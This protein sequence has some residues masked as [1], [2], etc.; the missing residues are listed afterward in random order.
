MTQCVN[1]PIQ[2][3]LFVVGAHLPEVNLSARSKGQ[4]Q[5]TYKLKLLK[6][7]IR[8]VDI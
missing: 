7:G 8:V 2:K 3:F 1:P 5:A 4:L 6:E